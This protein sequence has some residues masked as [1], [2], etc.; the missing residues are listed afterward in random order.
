MP[1]TTSR[2]ANLG[3]GAVLNSFDFYKTLV[4]GQEQENILI[5]LG[6]R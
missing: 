2:V 1:T 6:G 3:G 4:S 5:Y